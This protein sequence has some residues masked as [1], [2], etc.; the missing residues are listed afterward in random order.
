MDEVEALA[1]RV[2]VIVGGRVVASG[3]PAELRGDADRESLIRVRFPVEESGTVVDL[4]GRLVGRSSVRNGLLEVWTPAPTVDLHHLTGWAVE[5][6]AALEGL[7]VSR[8]T[9]EDIYLDLISQ[10]DE[11]KDSEPEA[12]DNG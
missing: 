6:E 1:D 12:T 2:L 9:L 5:R 11:E 10:G 8:P 4:L 7:E 3:T